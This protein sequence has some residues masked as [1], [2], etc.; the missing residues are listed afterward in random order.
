MCIKMN[1]H[2]SCTI[3]LIM[4]H[5]LI[6]TK[7]SGSKKP[8]ARCA[9]PPQTL[10]T[11][12]LTVR[13]TSM[14]TYPTLSMNGLPAWSPIQL[15]PSCDRLSNTRLDTKRGSNHALHTNV[16]KKMLGFSL[17]D[18][19]HSPKAQ[20]LPSNFSS[21]QPE[22]LIIPPNSLSL[23]LLRILATTS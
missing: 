2:Y 10:G 12:T 1:K 22:G 17:S 7:K 8:T 11:H 23:S 19:V 13:F 15:D 21:S 9:T 18:Y 16:L 20:A 5:C 6:V 3:L 14:Y 4:Y